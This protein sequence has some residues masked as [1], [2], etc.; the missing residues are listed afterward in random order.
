M[1][2]TAALL[3][4]VA[5]ILY[6]RL[7]DSGTRRSAVLYALAAA[8]GVWI[9]AFG[10][11][12]IVAHFAH[13]VVFERPWDTN[14]LR[15]VVSGFAAAVVGSLPVAWLVLVRVMSG[16]T[17][18]GTPEFTVKTVWVTLQG[19]LKLGVW[20]G[21]YQTFDIVRELVAL[22]VL[23]SVGGLGLRSLYA[24]EPN[25]IEDRAVTVP[26][27]VGVV[28]LGIIAGVSFLIEPMWSG[29]RLAIVAPFLYLA[30]GVGAG[31]VK[32][33][34]LSVVVVV[35]LVVVFSVGSLL[36]AAPVTRPAWDNGVD[37]L[38][39]NADGNDLVVSGNPHPQP[40][41]EYYRE[42]GDYRHVG[43]R[44]DW[45]SESVSSK[46]FGPETVWVI[47]YSERSDAARQILSESDQYRQKEMIEFNGG[48]LLTR[49]E[50]SVAPASR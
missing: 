20:T 49:Y 23:L 30:V 22:F 16:Q 35:G 47:G 21:S 8:T 1:Y 26:A 13:A 45:T 2:A 27:V 9:H 10:V 36:F 34:R 14:R 3:S 39:A 11:L 40:E 41:V 46:V 44:Y 18:G 48:L 19:L 5:T 38:D 24:A 37:Y 25:L 43:I 6:L 28:S 15:G 29:R 42:D 17:A 4:V 31:R 32:R 7:V 12:I 33:E 50:R